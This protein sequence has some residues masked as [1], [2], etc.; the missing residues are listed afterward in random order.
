MVIRHPGPSLLGY[1]KI[2][3][4][5]GGTRF[6]LMEF[7]LLRIAPG[8]SWSS[9]K[10]DEK[11][12]LLISG[13]AVLSW[14]DGGAA[15]SASAARRSLFDESPSVLHLASGWEARV[16]AGP[17]GAELAVT[18]T[19]NR[20]VFP[21]RFYRAQDCRSEERGKGTL[22]ET[23]TR[24][25]RT[26]FDA[27]TAPL[28]HLVLGE[29]V[30]SPGRWSS[31]PPHH[32]PQPEIYHYRFQ[33]E[34]G[35]GLAVKGSQAHVVRHRDTVLIREGEVHPQAAA[36]GYAMWYLW[37]IRHL[38]GN[39]YVQ[40]TFAPEHLWVNDPSAP[41]WAPPSGRGDTK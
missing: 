5:K 39:R 41:I 16:T 38:D 31:Y 3:D 29:V 20:S 1:E 11:A 22:G 23:S 2:V 26:V 32:H 18:R 24:I 12:M 19:E 21:P 35:F 15:E 30:N 34:G 14:Q 40:P 6:A 36:P 13:S 25:V 27:S 8:E 9:G 33:P 10:A 28:S 4:R 37:V 17:L 7:A